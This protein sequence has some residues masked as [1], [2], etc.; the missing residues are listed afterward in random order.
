MS[1][2]PKPDYGD[3]PKQETPKGV[4]IPVPKRDEIMRAFR[5]IAKPKPAKG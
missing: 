1:R 2:K 3:V 4:T 5:K